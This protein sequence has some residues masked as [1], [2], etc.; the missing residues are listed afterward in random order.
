MNF[1]TRYNLKWVTLFRGRDNDLVV[2]Y[3]Y[4]TPKQSKGIEKVIDLSSLP[5]NSLEKAFV[6]Y[7]IDYIRTC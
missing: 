2:R 3:A 5:S 1:L 4:D 6:D 7:Y